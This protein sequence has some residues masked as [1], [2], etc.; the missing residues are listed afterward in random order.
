VPLLLYLLKNKASSVLLIDTLLKLAVTLI[1]LDYPTTTFTIL[2]LLYL[3]VYFAIANY[4]LLGGI[5]NAA[6]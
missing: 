4:C 3:L 5:Y 2:L 1:Y 6:L